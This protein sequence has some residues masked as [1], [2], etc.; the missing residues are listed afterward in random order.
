MTDDGDNGRIVEQLARDTNRN[1]GTS[2]VVQDA[3]AELTAADAAAGVDFLYGK[4]G[5]ALH[6]RPAGFRER[7]RQP[8]DNRSPSPFA[9]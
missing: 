2:A 5:G 9:S 7:P 8:Y 3:Q 1:F 6:R 4:L